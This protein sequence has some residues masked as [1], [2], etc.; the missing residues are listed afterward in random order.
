M[1][2]KEKLALVY[3]TMER[4]HGRPCTVEEASM[5]AGCNSDILEV[6]LKEQDAARGTN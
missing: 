3:L 1:T 2:A 6:F 5:F 4:E